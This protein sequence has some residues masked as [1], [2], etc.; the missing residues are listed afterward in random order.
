MTASDMLRA[1]PTEPCRPWPRHIL[2][3]GAWRA[4]AAALALEPTVAL[5]AMWADTVDVHALFHDE[6]AGQFIP[7]SVPVVDGRYPGLSPRRPAAAWFERMIHDLWGHAPDNTPDPRPLARPRQMASDRAPVAPPGPERHRLL[8]PP[9]SSKP[10]A[11]T[12]ARYPSDPS[13]PASSSL[14]ISAF[15][16]PARPSRGSKSASAMPIKARCT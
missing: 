12:S 15:R 13:M 9:R 14:A 16:C 5:L 10:R 7:A 6:S 2:A 1:A 8:N 3:P 11:T 4:F